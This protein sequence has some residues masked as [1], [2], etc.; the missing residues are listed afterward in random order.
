MKIETR[1][2]FCRFCHAN[3]AI[4]VDV[5]DNRV[6]AVRGDASNPLFGGYTCCKGRQLPAQTHHASRLLSPRKRLPDGSSQKISSEKA[7]DEIAATLRTLI[8]RHGPRA[9]ASYNG[10]Y[11]FQ[12]S[13]ALPLARAFH[14]GLGSP[15]YFTSVTIDQPAKSYMWARFGSWGGGWHTFRDSDVV[16]LLGNNCFISHYSPPGGVP[17]FNPVRR[18]RDAQARGLK[19]ICVDPRRTEVARAADLHLQIRPGE[20]PT[21]L[22]GIIRIILE[23]G[24]HDRE[25]CAEN[26][27]SLD[28]LRDAVADFT[29]EYVA[30]RCGVP[31]AQVLA[32]ARM[33]ARGPRGVVSSGTG[34]ELAPHGTLTEHFIL[35]LNAI[36]GRCY[37]Q[38]EVSAI[39]RIFLPPVPRKAQVHS[40][41]PL[42][43]EGFHPSRIRGLTALAGE[44]PTPTAADEMLL[45]GA[46]Q[47][48]ALLCVGGNPVVAW[49]DQVKTHR[50]LRALDLLVCVDITLS[51]TAKLADYVI[52]PQVC[53]ER[54]D[55]T[56][57][58]DWWYEEPYA[59]YT[60]AMVT[61]A[62]DVVNEW[63]FFWE[64]ARRLDIPLD[65]PGGRLPLDKKPTTFQVLEMI[66]A[67][68][69]IPLAEIRA[70]TRA[71]GR[72][73]EGAEVIV[74]AADPEN[75]GRFH[76]AP[77]GVADE[78]RTLRGDT[79]AEGGGADASG[80]SY[81]HL[82]VSRRTGHFFNSSGHHIEALRR[83]GAINYAHL[84]PDDLQALRIES[85]GL[86]EIEAE[87]ACIVGVALADRTVKPGV[88]SM[89]HCFGDV[90][91]NR[92]NVRE[93]GS[94]TNRLAM[95]DKYFDPITGMVR[96][97]AIPVN[98]RPLPDTRAY[99]DSGVR[100]DCGSAV[101]G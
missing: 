49:P 85:D 18:L 89:A 31:I 64:L 63:E 62:G 88:V 60:E 33:F 47:I 2:S 78:I 59:F 77:S 87:N 97:S 76:L 50:A 38:G 39:P 55:A 53:L 68:A 95:T 72:I 73:F 56:L 36:C 84:H 24:L 86:I 54:E 61:P 81:T 7:F 75:R 57:L 80:R 29:P 93:K 19:V 99:Q 91:S 94:S 1:K 4:E 8:H 11:A 25:F 37:R 67:G 71:G 82:L 58:S 22:A 45:P 14:T 12:N 26:I 13:T 27:Q 70:A 90:D 65:L 51:A 28:A 15:S 66:T 17:P 52:A 16:M 30:R 41:K 46:G 6:I 10:S 5:A 92:E 83:K 40:P 9:I 100:T 79:A 74:Q 32:A 43:G 98:L 23:E 69:R 48:K 96:L 44:M 101:P 20:D 35:T 21:L 3:C 34:P 42:W